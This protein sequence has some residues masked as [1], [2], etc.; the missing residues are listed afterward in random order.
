MMLL[1]LQHPNKLMNRL[2]N[3]IHLL[4]LYNKIGYKYNNIFTLE[5]VRSFLDLES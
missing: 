1:L 4:I 3:Q 2:H 5:I